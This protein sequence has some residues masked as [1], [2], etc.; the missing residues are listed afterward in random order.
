MAYEEDHYSR[1]SPSRLL[2]ETPHDH[3]QEDR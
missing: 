1:H 3:D 2:K